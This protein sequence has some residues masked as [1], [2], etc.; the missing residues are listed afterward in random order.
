MSNIQSDPNYN[1]DELP[2][3]RFMMLNDISNTQLSAIGYANGTFYRTEFNN[4]IEITF[5]LGTLDT[6]IYTSSNMYL[7][8]NT[9]NS[10]IEIPELIFLSNVNAK[11]IKKAQINVNL[12]IQYKLT[13]SNDQN[14]INAREIRTTFVKAD[15]VTP[16]DATLIANN[17]PDTGSHDLILLNGYIDVEPDDIVKIKMQLFQD[18]A[19]SG[20]SDTKLTIFKILWNLNVNIDINAV[21]FV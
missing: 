1:K 6:G 18:N 4:N 14:Y 19:L 8:S 15:G 7:P 20:Q 13:K 12:Y 2:M 10:K 16:Y 11:A 17:M 5:P 21:Y 9:F 3:P